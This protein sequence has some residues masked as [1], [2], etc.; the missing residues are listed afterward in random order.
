[1]CCNLLGRPYVRFEAFTA[2]KCAEILSGDLMR[3]LKLSR[4]V[5]VLKS[6]RQIILVKFTT[7]TLMMETEEIFETL[8]FN[9]T[10]TRLIAREAFNSSS[11]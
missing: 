5:N 3:D 8:V 1:M 7:S 6:S 9:S 11:A 10:L 4:R 2:S